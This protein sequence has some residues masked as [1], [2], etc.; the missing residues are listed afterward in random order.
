MTY[1]S[2]LR[3]RVKEILDQVEDNSLVFF[4]GFSHQVF[5]VLTELGS[6]RFTGVEFNNSKPVIE[7]LSTKSQIVKSATNNSGKHWGFYEDFIDINNNINDLASIDSSIYIVE[8]NIFEEFYPIDKI[9]NKEQ[10]IKNMQNESIDNDSLEINYY[11]EHIVEGE[12][13]L[14]SLITFHTGIYSQS[15]KQLFSVIPFFVDQNSTNLK[16]PQISQKL[17]LHL[18][19]RTVFEMLDGK[20]NNV[21]FEIDSQDKRIIKRLRNLNTIGSY[22]GVSFSQDDKNKT[23]IDDVSEQHIEI[24]QRYWK[25]SKGYRQLGFY[26]NPHEGNEVKEISQGTIISDII[27]QCKL[28]INGQNYNDIIIT[29]PTG[30]GKSVMF[31]IPAIYLHTEHKMVTIVVTP[32]IALMQDQI[33]NLERNGVSFATFINSD[34]T[35]EQRVDRIQKIKRGEISI[36]YMSPESLLANDIRSYI[37]EREIGLMIVD[38]AH[39]VTSWGRDFRV[40]YWFLGDFIE[41]SRKGS[42]MRGYKNMQQFPVVCL[43]ATAVFGGQ[44]DVINELQ[45]SL[46][47]H[48]PYQSIYVGNVRRTNLIFDIIPRKAGDFDKNVDKDKQSRM[49]Q[50]IKEFVQNNEKAI[51]YYPFVSQIAETRER[52]RATLDPIL[53]ENVFSYTS[54]DM[55]RVEKDFAYTQFKERKNSVMLATKAFGMGVDISDIATV[56]HFAPTGTLSDYVQEIGRAARDLPQG[57]AMTDYYNSDMKYARTL[58]GLSGLRHYQLS[59][60]IRKLYDIFEKNK[61]SNLLFS[62]EVF[63]HIFA[64]QVD[65]KAKSALMLIASD[66][67]EKYNNKVIVVRPSN[68]FTVHY[69]DVNHTIEKEF[70]KK[71]GKYCEL[72]NDNKAIVAEYK[73]QANRVDVKRSSGS[74]YEIRLDR[75]W[76]DKFRDKSFASFKYE[77]FSGSLFEFDPKMIYAKSRLSIRYKEDYETLKPNLEKLGDEMYNVFNDILHSFGNRHFT[78]SDFDNAFKK[79]CSYKMNR[80]YTRILLGMFCLPDGDSHLPFFAER[81]ARENWRFIR[82]EKKGEGD[83][84]NESYSFV[85]KKLYYLSSNLRRYIGQCRPNSEE[86]NTFVAYLGIP[87]DREAK[88]P[89]EL[90]LASFLEMFNLATFEI[91][92]GKSSHIFVRI[93]N[94]KILKQITRSKEEYRNAPLTEIQKRHERAVDLVNRFMRASLSNEERWDVIE[95]YFLGNNGVVD[96]ILSKGENHG[97]DNT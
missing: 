28:A 40:D 36:I 3:S 27:K 81:E 73:N 29:A 53:K 51:V 8:N 1:R 79:H 11:T 96:E 18:L 31:Q 75:L 55:D 56:Y 82:I 78:F 39:I 87:R 41:K 30:A 24:L 23:I 46:N 22:F 70:L 89:E 72:V 94:A 58:W 84:F 17:S 13:I 45:T 54:R 37:G 76:E 68:M 10:F 2:F 47:I 80:E 4:Y 5:E 77:F 32:L 21:S 6:T 19:D 12:H 92:G 65:N 33:N 97:E 61:H 48:V 71:Y 83:P 38:E 16:N 95:H 85:E 49:V 62:P 9:E 69:I 67:L 64:E 90:F 91:A 26:S 44:D 52:I 25:S 42:Y 15:S 86:A 59:L 43:T 63:S 35:Y 7:Q 20:V 14:A 57:K 74:I 50:R 66:L 93:N 88:K 34:L 60:V